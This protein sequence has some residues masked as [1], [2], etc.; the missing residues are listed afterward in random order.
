M[1]VE[2]LPLHFVRHADLLAAVGRP[3]G[4]VR[5]TPVEMLEFNAVLAAASK[6]A[7]I[8]PL[9]F[10]TS[11]PNEAAVVQLLAARAGEL[12]AA[13]ERLDGRVEMTVRVR[14]EAGE[15][16]AARLAQIRERVEA[17]ET[18]SEVRTDR[19]GQRVVELAHLMARPE[20]AEYRRRLG[21][22]GL[23]VSGPWPPVHFLPQFLRMPMRRATGSG[24]SRASGA[25]SAG[26][27]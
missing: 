27:R 10:G 13:L 7:T 12:G 25:E 21:G 8:L 16:A 17:Q 15:S 23:E 11:F 22:E 4:G 24:T 9:R 20:E 14:L 18:W 2:R 1:A 5:P 19:A 6:R 3:G 26:R